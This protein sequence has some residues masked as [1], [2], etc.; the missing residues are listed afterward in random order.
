M[1][2]RKKMNRKR[3]LFPHVTRMLVDFKVTDPGQDFHIA[4]ASTLG[5]QE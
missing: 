5:K 1:A 2:R 4:I 3:R